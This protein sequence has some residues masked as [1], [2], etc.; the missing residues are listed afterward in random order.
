ML[1]CVGPELGPYWLYPGPFWAMLGHF[2][3]HWERIGLVLS[4]FS[5]ILLFVFLGHM[6]GNFG[7]CYVM[8]DILG[9]VGTISGSC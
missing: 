9:H 6:L 7:I 4:P 8:L 3:P 2:R 5:G 1:A